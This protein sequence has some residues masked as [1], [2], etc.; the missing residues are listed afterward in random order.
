MRHLMQQEILPYLPYGIQNF[1]AGLPDLFLKQI[2]EIR[3]RG[4]RP[5]AFELGQGDEMSSY[6]VSREEMQAVLQLLSRSSVYA[7]EEELRNGYLTL[8]GGHRVGFVGRAV[9]EKGSV[10]VLKDISGFNIRISRECIGSADLIM[11][12]IIEEGQVKNT[13]LIAPPKAGKTTLLRDLIRQLSNG[14]G[15]INGRKIGLVDERSEIAAVYQG[16]PQRDIGLRTDV[17]DACPKAYGMMLLVRSMS[18]EV[19][20]TDE[21][22]REEDIKA[23]EEVLCAGVSIIASAHGESLADLKKRPGLRCILEQ[24]MFERFIFLNRGHGLEKILDSNGRTLCS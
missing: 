18:P 23:L 15:G 20:V 17:L 4:E 19:I 1:I 21:I 13:L 22:G 9:L 3:L 14:Q 6:F 12:Y 10:K 7:L 11:P 8:R 5:L 2:Q 16:I 24:Q